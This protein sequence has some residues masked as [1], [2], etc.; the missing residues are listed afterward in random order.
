MNIRPLSDRVL[1]KAISSKVE[2][3]SW[4]YL[5]E[6]AQKERPFMY[7]VIS[8]WPWK[9]GVLMTLKPGD[10][11]LSGQYSWDDV[12]VEWNDYKIVAMDY[13]LAVIED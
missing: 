4:I 1:L 9:E 5:P 11:V 3:Q 8:V 10:K 2:S 6:S 7:E 13:I 12:K